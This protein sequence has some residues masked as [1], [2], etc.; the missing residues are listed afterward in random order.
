MVHMVLKVRVIGT[1]K[2]EWH[3]WKERFIEYANN[4][5]IR[6]GRRKLVESEGLCMQTLQK[7]ITFISYIKSAI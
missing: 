2:W 5:N 6:R 1:N 7:G 3:F 4:A